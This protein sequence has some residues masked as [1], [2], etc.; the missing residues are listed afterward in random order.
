MSG[1]LGSLDPFDFRKVLDPAAGFDDLQTTPD[2]PLDTVCSHA[3]PLGQVTLDLA[4]AFHQ[5]TACSCPVA[6][7]MMI[8]ADGK[9]NQALEK[10]PLRLPGRRPDLF[11]NLVALEKLAAV[12]KL[13]AAIE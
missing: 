1:G 9:V 3:T 2:L 10:P 4:Q 13:D 11:K 6:P 8:E 5:L 12:E 7:L